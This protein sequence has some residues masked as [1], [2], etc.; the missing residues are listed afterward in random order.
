[1]ATKTMPSRSA[2][3]PTKVTKSSVPPNQTLYCSNLTDKLRKDDLRLS[4][5]TLFST[6]GPVLDVV[7]LKTMKMRGQAHI[8]FR[9]VHS[10]TQAMRALQ[11]FEFFGKEMKIQYAKTKSDTISKLDGTFKMPSTQVQVSELQQSIFNAP[12][13]S[14]NTG[15][16]QSTSLKP[17]DGGA[18]GTS[19]EEGAKSPQGVKRRRDDE[20]DDEDAPMDEDDDGDAP[21]ED[22]SEE[23]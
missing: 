21:M 1:M 6:Y 3:P 12:P 10:S 15:P 14:T 5:Y 16:T 11:G 17:P 8:T 19:A 2:P 13:S 4:L 22:S 18:A 9:D 20:S 7:A 23:D